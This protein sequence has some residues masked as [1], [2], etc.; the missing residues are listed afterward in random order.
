M[1]LR[2]PRRSIKTDPFQSTVL[3]RGRFIVRALNA[4]ILDLDSD[5]IISCAE[6]V[7]V[8]S[9]FGVGAGIHDPFPVRSNNRLKKD[10][11]RGQSKLGRG[12]WMKCLSFGLPGLR[13]NA[14][15]N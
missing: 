10:L 14:Y 8:C 5:D 15:R 3:R 6:V 9:Q 4:L 13:K 7:T 1:P 2:M 11:G 12:S